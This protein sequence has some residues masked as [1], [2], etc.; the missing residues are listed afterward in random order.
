MSRLKQSGKISSSCCAF[1]TFGC[2]P[3]EKFLLGGGSQRDR[4]C[5]LY[6]R[7]PSQYEEARDTGSSD[8]IPTSFRPFLTTSTGTR[9][10]RVL[11][12]PK[13]KNWCLKDGLD[14]LKDVQAL[15]FFFSFCLMDQLG[16]SRCFFWTTQMGG[17]S[18]TSIT[19]RPQHPRAEGR[20]LRRT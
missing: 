7:A 2:F 4:N 15:S 16:P 3:G 8:I 19:S 5:R 20:G 6:Y 18:I 14:W 10:G 11:Q 9:H 17:S 1:E 13:P 12:I